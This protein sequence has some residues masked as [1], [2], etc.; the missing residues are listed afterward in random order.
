MIPIRPELQA[1]PRKVVD[2]YL[3]PGLLNLS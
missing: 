2:S 3:K 1:V